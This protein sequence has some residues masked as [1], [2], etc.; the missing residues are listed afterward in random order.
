MELVIETSWP[1]VVASF[2]ASL[3]EAVEALTIVLAIGGVRGWRS[4]LLGTALAFL[5]LL[6]LVVIVGAGVPYIPADL[7]QLVA[8]GLL[9]LFGL[10]WLR[11]AILRGA[12]IIAMRDENAAFRRETQKIHWRERSGNR[13]V[14]PSA[15][16]AAFQGVMSEG[17]EIVVVVIAVGAANDM[18]MPAG[19]AAVGAMIA[20]IALGVAMPRPA[21]W[22]PENAIKLV[23]GAALSGLGTFWAGTGIGAVWLGGEE[24]VFALIAAYF[25]LAIALTAL[26]WSRRL[27]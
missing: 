1:P 6:A 9:L 25:V 5:V 26:A 12:R 8:G 2:M 16:A 17:A 21:S 20:V 22:V 23:V 3:V 19:L 18:M 14:D 24:A 11:T 4:A 10:R 7:V 27:V 15:I 13:A